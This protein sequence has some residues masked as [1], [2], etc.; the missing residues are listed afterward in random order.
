MSWELVNQSCAQPRRSDAASN[1]ASA[2]ERRPQA[3][4]RVH[5]QSIWHAISFNKSSKQLLILNVTGLDIVIKDM[6][7]IRE[8]ISVIETPAISICRAFLSV[9]ESTLCR[10]ILV[11]E[12]QRSRR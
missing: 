1:S 8:R 9:P 10:R 4:V 6:N 7:R 2:P 5:R 3:T 11:R 12:G